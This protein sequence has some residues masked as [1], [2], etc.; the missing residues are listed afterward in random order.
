MAAA[1]PVFRARPIWLIGSKTTA[2]PPARA[3]SAVRSV[4]LLSQTMI[5]L[6][7]PR[8]VNAVR[9]ACTARSVAGNSFSS[10]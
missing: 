2:A 3:T 10:L 5:S 8:S 9:A 6:S 1:A 4:E 7:Q